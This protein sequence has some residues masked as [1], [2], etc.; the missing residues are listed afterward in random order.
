[1]AETTDS[2]WLPPLAGLGE[3]SELHVASVPNPGT[4]VGDAPTDRAGEIRGDFLSIMAIAIVLI[5]S[6]PILLF[7]R[8]YVIEFV[9]GR[10]HVDI[11][12]R[13]CTH[14]LALPLH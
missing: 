1:M 5:L 8:T 11:K 13:V 7:A 4:D 14:L 12:Q 9:L 10:I 6:M 3:K 2:S